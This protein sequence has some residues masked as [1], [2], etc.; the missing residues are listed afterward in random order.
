MKNNSKTVTYDSLFFNSQLM[1]DIKENLL[2]KDLY[3]L[4][5]IYSENYS[6]KKLQ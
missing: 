6:M 4:K 1:S 5:A 2:K 3:L